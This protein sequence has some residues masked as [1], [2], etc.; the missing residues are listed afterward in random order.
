MEIIAAPHL[1]ARQRAYLTIGN[2]GGAVSLKLLIY[3]VFLNLP[4]ILPPRH[5]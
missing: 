1:D 2:F 4:T 5:L 3:N